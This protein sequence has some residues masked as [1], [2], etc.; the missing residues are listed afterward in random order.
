MDSYI[1]SPS[2]IYFL[3]TFGCLKTFFTALG[4]V[5]G[6]GTLIVAFMIGILHDE[7]LVPPSIKKIFFIF[8][9]ILI[10]MSLFAILVPSKTAMLEM[11]VARFATYENAEWTIDSIKSVVDYIV[12]AISTL[13]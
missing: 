7:G 9:C 2:W 5:S 4:V 10:V 6:I 12:N 11:T 8:L 3:N 1:I 13:K